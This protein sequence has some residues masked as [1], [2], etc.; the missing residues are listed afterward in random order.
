M[1]RDAV[2]TRAGLP[3]LADIFALAKPSIM[4]FSLLTAVGGMSLAPAAQSLGTWI[5]LM[6]GTALIVGSANT[7]NMYLERDVDCLMARTRNRPLPGGRMDP[8]FALSFGV[9]QAVIAVPLLTFGTNP[10]TGFLG[11]V[12]LISYVNFYTPLKQRTTLATLVGSLPGAMP[13]L[14]GFTAATNRLELGGLA[15]FG[16]LFLWQIPHFHAIALYRTK[17]YERAG[18]KILP[19]E[20]GEYGTRVTMLLYLIAQVAVSVLVYTVGVAGIWYLITAIAMGGAY[21]AYGV[22]G[23]RRDAGPRWARRFFL[24][25]IVYLP[26]LF[27]VLVIDGVH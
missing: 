16:V 18:L 19:S 2:L 8:R 15:V 13:A 12:A 5:S 27:T 11:V 7:L 6:L 24:A 1:S 3:A 17:D 20:R 10:L 9:V 23:L 4:V 21:L 14:M 25:S 22:L 26:V